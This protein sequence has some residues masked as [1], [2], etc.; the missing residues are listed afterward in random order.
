MS[1]PD[2]TTA[3]DIDVYALSKFGGK[4]SRYDYILASSVEQVRAAPKGDRYFFDFATNTLYW[5]VISGF[6]TSEDSFDWVDRAAKSITDFTRKGSIVVVSI[7]C[8]D[9]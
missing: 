2:G 5:R 9:E 6:A 1:V 7:L 8:R 4:E 3:H